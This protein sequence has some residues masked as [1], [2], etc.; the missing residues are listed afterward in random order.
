[1]FGALHDLKICVHGAVVQGGSNLTHAAAQFVLGLTGYVDDGLLI[2]LGC[3]TLANDVVEGEHVAGLQNGAVNGFTGQFQILR[4]LVGTGVAGAGGCQRITEQKFL[5]GSGGHFGRNCAEGETQHVACGGH[6]QLRVG[7]QQRN[8]GSQTPGFGFH[9]AGVHVVHG[10]DGIEGILVIEVVQLHGG[11]IDH[12][13]LKLN[14]GVVVVDESTV[15]QIVQFLF[16]N[17]TAGRTDVHLNGEV[18]LVNGDLGFHQLGGYLGGGFAD[19]IADIIRIHLQGRGNVDVIGAAFGGVDG[20]GNGKG[21]RAFAAVGVGFLHRKVSVHKDGVLL[22]SEG[23]H[24]IGQDHVDA[25]LLGFG[26]LL[27]DG[28]GGFCLGHAAYVDARHVDVGQNLVVV[29]V[30]HGV[31]ADAGHGSHHQCQKHDQHDQRCS[32]ALLFLAGLSGS[33]LRGGRPLCAGRTGLGSGA[34]TGGG[35]GL[36][37]RTGRTAAPVR[38]FL[39]AVYDDLHLS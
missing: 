15:N 20:T 23:Q 2:A 28:G 10:V 32:A 17:G 16:V 33:L 11:G 3:G 39:F 30:L 35:S 19:Q 6:S 1:M 31:D 14:V 38:G 27:V 24:L 21:I 12:V 26:E 18:G 22:G 34:G 4:T 7:L 13:V 37:S 5:Q 36:R 29:H 25:L 9:L 8:G